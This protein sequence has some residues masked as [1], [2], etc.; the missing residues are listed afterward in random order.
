MTESLDPSHVLA[1]LLVTA[2]NPAAVLPLDLPC[3]PLALLVDLHQY[4]LAAMLDDPARAQRAAAAAWSVIARFPTDPLLRAQAHWTQASAIL[5][6]PDYAG[7]LAHY[8]AALTCYDRA[9]AL[10][11]PSTPARDIRVVHVVRVFCLT[12]LGRY[13]EAIHAATTAE[14]W[15]HEH[16]NS[17]AQLTLV[18]NRSLLAG[19]MG[20]YLQ[21]L[22]WA[23]ETV[24]V[25]RE[26]EQLAREAQG[27]INRAYACIFLG[28]FSES[29]TALERGIT[30]AQ[31][32]GETLTVARGQYNRARLLRCQGLLFAALTELRLAEQSFLQAPGEA[33]TI[34][35]EA[36]ALY[37]QLRQLPEAR[38]A[39]SFAS[40]MFAQQSMAAYS[41]EAA[42]LSARIAI[43]QK[44]MS[45][46]TA[47][48]EGACSQIRAIVAPT[49]VAELALAD[50]E[51]TLLSVAPGTRGATRILRA[52]YAT[53]SDAVARLQEHGLVQE[54]VEG[55]FTVAMLDQHL[56]RAE[57]ATVAYRALLDHP[58][59]HTQL[60]AHAELGA[61]LP[62]VDA[63]SY[64]RRAAELA[65]EQRRMLPMEEIQARYSSEMSS[66][67]L[68]L[69]AC[70]LALNDRE[71]A[72]T[73]I[74][75]AKAGALLDLRAA[76]GTLD[77]AT[78]AALEVAKADL[79]RRRESERE[80]L[81]KAQESNL[82]LQHEGVAYHIEQAHR[83]ANETQE[84]ERHLTERLRLLGDRNGQGNLPTVGEVQR[85]LPE[86][87]ALLEFI[88]INGELYG[89][90]LLS[91]GP[92]IVRR[93]GA[94][95]NVT[96]L[97]DRWQ[98]V[99]HR[100]LRDQYVG[101]AAQQVQTALAPLVQCL[102]TPW[103]AELTH[104]AQ[105]II[106]PTGVLHDLPWVGMS[107]RLP[108]PQRSVVLTPCGAL[109]LP[110]EEIANETLAPPLLLGYAGDD[111]RRLDYVPIELSTIAGHLPEVTV[112]VAATSADLRAGS[113]PY[114]LHLAAHAQTNTSLPLCSTIELADG[115]FLL[116][117]AHR[118]NLRGTRL[119]ILSACETG[120]RPECGEMVLAI[121]GAFIC[122]GAQAVLASLW[123][124]SDA[125]TAAL[126][127]RLYAALA[128]GATLPQAL[129][130]AQQA[131]RAIAPLDWMAF[132]LWA[133]V[134]I[135]DKPL[136]YSAKLIGKRAG[137]H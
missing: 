75:G 19:R 43:Q 83:A 64:L 31:R 20:D 60:A 121:A 8:D 51:L 81:R 44:Q 2:S 91:Q 86:T 108:G 117:E 113:P 136:L 110:P 132:Q 3:E 126:M 76:G 134:Q 80:H 29:S 16:P 74:W 1:A 40:E 26:T 102:L 133:G 48:L 92:L 97:I 23:D 72:L 6:V 73:S 107:D 67:H 17:Y 89:F 53:A 32:A 24:T 61:L 49:L 103:L 77:Q 88:H 38:R 119:V 33:A 66:H 96:A 128:L 104:I 30:T 93:L 124:V 122:A 99:C 130:D 41:A 100:L 120:V 68:R 112:R 13:Q 7:S 118:L 12:E 106:A 70:Q 45:I 36:A 63:L 135:P 4:A 127:D 111:A 71:G 62:P 18:L 56:G 46:A 87:A 15:L 37:E 84:Y 65:V 137:D 39:A 28:R 50:A 79:M 54:A 27:W 105:L 52:A 55:L 78:I 95:D 129:A 34:A 125:V 131:V 42:I 11:T 59:P 85:S 57:A 94:Y 14:A 114:L 5:Y 115:P 69:A 109:L 21:M 35:L 90:L 98:I 22:Q 123:P 116:I 58:S 101:N 9:C 10:L 25:A 47:M 82:Q